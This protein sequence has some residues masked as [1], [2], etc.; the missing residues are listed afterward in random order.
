M[1]SRLPYLLVAICLVALLAPGCSLRGDGRGEGDILFVRERVN[2]GKAIFLMSDDGRDVRRLVAGDSPRWSPDGTRFAYS[3]RGTRGTTSMFVMNPDT[4]EKQRIASTEA[5][6]FALA[7]APDGV[8]I[9]YA[10]GTRTYVVNTETGHSKPVSLDLFGNDTLDWS[11]DGR[12]LLVSRS[13]VVRVLDLHTGAERQVLPRVHVDGAKWS[14]DGERIALN[15]WNSPYNPRRKAFDFPA[16]GVFKSAI[17][18]ADQNGDGRQR[19][20]TGAFDADPAWSDDGERIYFTRSPSVRFDEGVFESDVYVA[21]LE[22]PSLRRLTDT[23]VSE[24]SPDA[25]PAHRSLADPP[26]PVIGDVVVPD[27]VDQHVLFPEAQRR[28]RLLG[29]KLRAVL[30]VPELENWLLV[31][32]DQ[33]P[34]GGS[35]VPRGTVVKVH[36]F[37]LAGIYAHFRRDFSA[38]R[39][40]AQPGCEAVGPRAR[41]YWDLVEHVLRRGMSRRRALSLLG[42]PGRSDGESAAWPVGRLS[43]ARVDCIYLR[44]EFDRRGRVTRFYQSTS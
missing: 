30:P 33:V 10:D 8:R 22:T 17:V 40:K 20:T 3:V 9:A 24:R 43:T 15:E 7:W 34:V 29:L 11:P 36:G 27:L 25:R 37:D 31:V 13:A 12:K 35:R 18:V 6:I 16:D 44:V 41:M 23:A 38:E 39:W 14:P 28:F 2:G 5:S 21:D 26:E 4:G 1:S 42:E 19:V 32:G